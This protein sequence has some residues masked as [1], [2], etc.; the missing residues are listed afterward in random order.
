MELLAQNTAEDLRYCIFY[1]GLV[2][3][4]ISV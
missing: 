1:H 3:V 2:S 4:L